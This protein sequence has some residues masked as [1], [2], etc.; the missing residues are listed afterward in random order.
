MKQAEKETMK[1]ALKAE[2]LCCFGSVSLLIETDA[3]I[4]QEGLPLAKRA[5]DHT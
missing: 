3:C 4:Y 1:V 5:K 2:V